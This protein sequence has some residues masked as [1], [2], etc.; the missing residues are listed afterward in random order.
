MRYVPYE[1]LGTTPNIVVDGY[2]T[3]STVLSLS[4][5]PKSGT[6]AHLKADASA[7]IVLKWLELGDPKVEASAV[8]NNHFDEDGLTGVWSVLNPEKALA[9]RDLIADVA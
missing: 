1:S 9:R 7:E 8:S 3:K 6:P 5:W 2:G 4:H